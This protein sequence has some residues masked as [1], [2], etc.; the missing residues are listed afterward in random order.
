MDLVFLIGKLFEQCTFLHK[1]KYPNSTFLAH[2]YTQQSKDVKEYLENISKKNS[3]VDSNVRLWAEEMANLGLFAYSLAMGPWPPHAPALDRGIDS[4]TIQAR[5]EGSFLRD[6][7][8]EMVQ[9]LEYLVRALS[10][11]HERLHHSFT[12]YLL[13]T[14]RTFVSHV[15]YLLP[16]ILLLL[17]LAV[18]AFGLILWGNGLHL[19]TVGCAILVSVISMGIMLLSSLAGSDNTTVNT[20]LFV[21][22]A[23]SIFIWKK[24]SLQGRT[25]EEY[26]RVLESLQFVACAT[27]VY[28]HV[29]IAFAHVSLAYLP[30][31][32]WTPLLAFPNYGSDVRGSKWLTW[33]GVVLLFVT[34]PPILLVPRIFDSYTTYVQFAYVPLHVQL[35]LLVMTRLLQ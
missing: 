22:Y 13:P 33:L 11:L 2:S 9:H 16:N 23:L 5:F 24:Q 25:K 12:L 3:L 28:M 6:P 15:E 14:P 35:L 17:P 27:A 19:Q 29:P 7:S 1:S 18:R 4:I 31:M 26:Q 10:N 21:L 8:N 32:L 20:W 34:A 30:S